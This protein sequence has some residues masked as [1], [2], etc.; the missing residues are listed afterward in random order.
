MTPFKRK[1]VEF[2]FVTETLRIVRFIIF[3]AKLKAER[4]LFKVIVNAQY[5]RVIT[6]QCGLKYHSEN[7]HFSVAQEN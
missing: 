6:A 2:F 1:S 7:M 5:C 4:F 3:H